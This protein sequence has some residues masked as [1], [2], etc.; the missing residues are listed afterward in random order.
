MGGGLCPT[1]TP[2]GI[3]AYGADAG[4][5]GVF[6]QGEPAERTGGPGDLKTARGIPLA[7]LPLLGPPDIHHGPALGPR[8][9]TS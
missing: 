1:H 4:A 6:T 9:P 5:L 3:G 8:T 7:L 2:P